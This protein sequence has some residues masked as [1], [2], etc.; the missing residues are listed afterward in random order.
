LIDVVGEEFVP[1]IVKLLF[2]L[3]VYQ[4]NIKDLNELVYKM[5]VR[6]SLRDLVGEEGEDDE[7]FK[8]KIRSTSFFQ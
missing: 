5:K 8:N 3:I 1:S 2:L 7:M 6:V 4:D